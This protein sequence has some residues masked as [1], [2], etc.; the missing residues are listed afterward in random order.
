MNEQIFKAYDVRGTYPDQVNEAAFERIARAY[1]QFLKP[2]TVAVGRDVRISGERLQQAVITGLTAMGVNVIDI[3]IG[4]TEQ[5]YFAVGS[6]NLDG[7][8]QVSASHNPA[9]YNGLKMIKAG[10]EAISGD[11]GLL[12]IKAL[13][14]GNTPL[15]G[16]ST[17]TVKHQDVTDEYLRYIAKLVDLQDLRPV[18]IVTNGNFGMS[19]LLA[20]RLI[21]RMKLPITVIALNAEPDGTFPKGRPDPLIAENRAETT[22]LVLQHHADMGVAWDADGDRCYVADEN[23]QFIEGCHMTALL[24]AHLLRKYPGEKVLYDPRNVYAAEYAITTAGGVPIE[25]KTG[26]AFI[27]NRMKQENSIF[28]GEMSGHYY[29][30]DFF[31]ADNGLLTFLY[32]LELIAISGNKKVSEIAQPL[33]DQFFVSGEINFTV[34]DAL[35][36]I[37]DV[38]QHYPAAKL[39]TTDGVSLNFDDWRCNIRSSN[40]EPLLRLNVEAHSA[41]TCQEKTAELQTLLAKHQV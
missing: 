23:G 15:V 36:A 29:Y 34:T 27:K 16:S 9:E 18:T 37:A 10:V 28:A 22:A 5:L 40:T 14:L 1:A 4:P 21:S 33:R 19:A 39:D 32:F 17:G 26:H 11:T 31:R 24:A 12:E 13:A 7:G 20:K 3:G 25:T 8:I 35:A 2:K 38:Q 30:R 41:A 6:L